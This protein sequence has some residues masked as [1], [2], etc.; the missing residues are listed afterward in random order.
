MSKFI[1]LANLTR[2]W[3]KVKNYIDNGL[4]GK[5]DAEH[6]HS[7]YAE[8]SHTHEQS[9]IN[10]LVTAL[11]EKAAA[12]HTHSEYAAASHSHEVASDEEI[13]ALFE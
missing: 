12:D 5:A 13:D 1:N 10:G 2:F 8:A 9:E 4:S 3:T 6:T 7:G 11:A